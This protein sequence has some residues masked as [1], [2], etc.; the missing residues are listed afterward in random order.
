MRSEPMSSDVVSSPQVYVRQ[1]TGLVRELGLWKTIM[2]NLS[3]GSIPFAL[4]VATSAYAFPGAS[5]VLIVILSAAGA[6]VLLGMYGMLAGAMPR[7]GGDFIFVGRIIHPLV[8]FVSSFNMI[9]W[10][11]AIVAQLGA[12]LAPF[13]VGAALAAWGSA[14]GNQGLVDASVTVSSKAWS[15]WLAAGVFLIAF[16]L[17]NLRIETWSRIFVGVFA[18]SVAG[19]VVAALLMSFNGRA[20][21]RESLTGL[22]VDYDSVIASARDAG[23]SGGSFSFP[24]T[25]FATALGFTF[26]GYLIFG[27]FAGGEIRS[28]SRNILRSLWGAIAVGGIGLVIVYALA[29]RTFGEDFLASATYL[30]FLSPDNYPFTVPSFLLFYA[31]LLT[32]NSIL[33]AIVTFSLAFA[34]I[35]VF[36][37]GIVS[38]SRVLFAWAFDRILPAKV[39]DVSERTH[40]PL[41]ANIVILIAYLI[42][43]GLI[44]YGPAAF[45][46]L[47][48]TTVL[49]QLFTFLTVAVAATIFPWRR[50]DLYETSP[51]A[52][53]RLF[54]L[55]TISVLGALSFAI[56]LFYL[57]SFLTNDSLGANNNVGLVGV[58]VA[59]TV[60]FLIYGASYFLNKR[61]GIDITLSYQSLPPE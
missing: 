12:I 7:S 48:F 39:A 18:L 10:I 11:M 43:L 56:Y 46:T 1:S 36:F 22:G 29:A 40:S 41:I 19:V 5:L 60:P 28:A 13:S 20:D 30:E 21:F 45:F 3:F 2:L 16:V 42:F 59:L 27:I 25:I 31:S 34:T 14:T 61:R 44:V 54:G 49:G 33:I 23:F 51:L 26:F 6:A 35:A 17:T 32:S 24:Q 53:R 38:V 57:V 4:F 8:G 47:T 52:G 37:V 58:V 9:F 50:R 15:F 55:P